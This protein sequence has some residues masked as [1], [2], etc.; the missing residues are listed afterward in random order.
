MSMMI[1]ELRGRGRLVYSTPCWKGWE[2]MQDSIKRVAAVLA[3][4]V[5]FAAQARAQDGEDFDHTFFVNVVE[6]PDPI[7]PDDPTAN[8]VVPSEKVEVIEDVV[9][10]PYA[11]ELPY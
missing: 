11:S 9:D 4:L 3:L 5:L 1:D 6:G 7:L 10:L 8:E 2:R